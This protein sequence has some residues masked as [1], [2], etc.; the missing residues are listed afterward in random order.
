M[1]E[2]LKTILII[3]LSF[4]I[5]Y[6]LY[7]NHYKDKEDLISDIYYI[8]KVD[9]FIVNKP[10]LID[11]YITKTIR[12][13]LTDTLYNNV[14]VNI[15]IS[16]NKYKDTI[17]NNLNDTAIVNS[18]VSGYR[19]KLDSLNVIFKH[20]DKV[21]VKYNKPKK[22]CVSLFGGYG[23]GSGGVSPIIGVG[24]SYSFISF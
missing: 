2:K 20:T 4:I 24:I 3:I 11:K 22:F 19:A 23:V 14:I 1:I 21:I 12:D 9:T 10:R 15:P 16:T 17:T 7:I 18:Y 8:N 6:L 13:T 5:V